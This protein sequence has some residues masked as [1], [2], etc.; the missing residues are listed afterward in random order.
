M[1]RA[2]ILRGS[3]KRHERLVRTR[4]KPRLRQLEP[5]FKVNKWCNIIQN[6]LYPPT[7]VLCGDT[8]E[9]SLDLCRPCRQA[10]PGN[11]HPCPRCGEPLSEQAASGPCGECQRKPPAFDQ[12]LALFHYE[13][14]V[15]RLILD[16]KFRAAYPNARLLGA[17]LAARL[18]VQPALPECIIPVPLHRQRYRERGF[19]QATEIAR[20]VAKALNIPLDLR[21][22][23]RVRATPPQSQLSAKERRKNL[24]RAF[25]VVKPPNARHAA[26]IDDVITTGATLDELALTLKKAGVLRVDAWACARA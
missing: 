16:L 10:L 9:A 14:P 21:S 5:G 19:N 12:A 8:G 26:L 15:R 1:A 17:L 13:D 25:E 22:C 20:H 11:L 3:T 7:C 2:F 6:C 4:C 23:V 24:K 18:K